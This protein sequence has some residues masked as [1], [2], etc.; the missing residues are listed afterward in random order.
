MKILI[1]DYSGHPFQVQLSRELANR[2]HTVLHT[3]GAMVP[4]PRGAIKEKKNDP[5]NF[6]VKGVS[7]GE[8]FSRYTY[9]K[10]FK[11]ERKF[12]RM[13][14]RVIDRFSPDVVISANTPL[15]AQAIIQKKCLD[16]GIKFIFWLQDLLGVG[17][18]NNVRKKLPVIWRAIGWYYISLE[19]HL[20]RKSNSVVI[21]TADFYPVMKKARVKNEN[22]Y[23]IHNWAPLEEMPIFPKSNQWSVRHK[24]DEK[25]C[26]IYSGTLGM[27]HNPELLVKLAL[28]LRNE[29]EI[30]LVIITEG[31]GAAYLK[32]KKAVY[33]LDNLILMPFQTYENLPQVLASADILVAI[34]EF[35]AGIFAVPSKVFT[36]MCA[37]K[38]LLLAVP[39]EN[40][41]AR[42]VQESQAGIIVPPDE[43]EQFV[44]AAVRLEKDANLRRYFAGNGRAYAERTFDIQRIADRFEKII[45]N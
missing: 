26:F 38:P 44:E 10:R 4:T 15:E 34:L 28:R 27:K 2:G 5:K 25:F 8:I 33:E 12:G 31:L 9:F 35:D 42:I 14:R 23:V 1:N 45:V 19:E 16:D 18:K 7:I 6:N 24:L 39:S 3:Y 41:A 32:E 36:Y 21:I 37:K 43:P 11:Q 20:L 30:R 13:M 17:I 40:L 29:H 22:I